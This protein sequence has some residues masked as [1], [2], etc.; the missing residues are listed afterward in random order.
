MNLNTYYLQ[1]EED[2]QFDVSDLDKSLD[3]IIL[4]N[5]EINFINDINNLDLLVLLILYINSGIIMDYN[6]IYNISNNN[7]FK[8]Y[9]SFNEM[10][11]IEFTLRKLV[12]LD[13]ISIYNN[14]FY[15]NQKGIDYLIINDVYN[16][17]FYKLYDKDDVYN[18][19]LIFLKKYSSEQYRNIF[20][21]KTK[22]SNI[23]LAFSNVGTFG[24]EIATIIYPKSVGNASKGGC[25][26]DNIDIES[27]TG[28]IINAREIKTACL[29]Q[30]KKCENNHKV[31]YF[32]KKC[33]I[34][35]SD[36]FTKIKDTRFSI[37]AKA[38]L[39]Y[40]DIISEYLLFI[41]DFDDNNETIKYECYKI[42]S[43]NYYFQLYLKNQLEKS[44]KSVVCNMVPYKLDFYLSGAIKL[45]DIN[46]NYENNVN[47]NYFDLENIKSQSIPTFLFTKIEKITYNIDNKEQFIDY[48]TNISKFTIRSKNLNKIRGNIDRI[49]VNKKRKCYDEN[50]IC[51]EINDENCYKENIMDCYKTNPMCYMRG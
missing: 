50:I 15:I 29:I 37:D 17:Y 7:F 49:N 10:M 27:S 20:L 40:N 43:N 45:F 26:F 9:S 36:D 6:T 16:F 13:L 18:T 51:S 39:K 11:D 21:E 42:Y 44:E 46:V 12:N 5:D 34:C 2:I 4:Q 28:N 47:I 38:Q 30:P 14:S 35:Y 48:E 1:N 33:S 8:Q 32:Q 31:P 24:E 22:N 25:S 41:I 19:I 3:D 23:S